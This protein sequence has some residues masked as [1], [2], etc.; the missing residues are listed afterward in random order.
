MPTS[1]SYNNFKD[2]VIHTRF[3]ESGKLEELENLIQQHQSLNKKLSVI[4]IRGKDQQYKPSRDIG[5]EFHFQRVG[6]SDFL[7]NAKDLLQKN[8]FTVKSF[9]ENREKLSEGKKFYKD[10]FLNNLLE[11]EKSLKPLSYRITGRFHILLVIL[12]RLQ[13]L[14]KVSLSTLIAVLAFALP[15]LG[16]KFIEF[17]A[18]PKNQNFLLN[19]FSFVQ[20]YNVSIVAVLIVIENIH[21]PRMYQVRAHPNI[22]YLHF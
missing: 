6:K 14:A 7:Q 13:L 1:A 20:Q 21:M 17:A 4:I 19:I 16:F 3:R 15:I 22:H 12:K 5:E 18:A 10:I 11:S 2:F 9:L 8:K